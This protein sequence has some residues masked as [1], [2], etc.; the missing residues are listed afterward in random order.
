MAFDAEKVL[1]IMG[2]GLLA[3]AG[4]QIFEGMFT[5]WIKTLKI[6]EIED[7]IINDKNLWDNITPGWQANLVRYGPRMGEIGKL[8]TFDWMIKTAAKCNPSLASLFLSWPEGQE[9][10]KLN[11]EDLKSHILVK[12]PA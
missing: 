9:W 4:P 6:V 12:T 3:I 2:S 11:L 8:L 1:N 10:L 7:W 5:E